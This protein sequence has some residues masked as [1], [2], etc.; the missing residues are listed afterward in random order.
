MSSACTSID[1]GD[2]AVCYA[3]RKVFFAENMGQC[4]TC[5][6]DLCLNLPSC[7]DKCKCDEQTEHSANNA[8]PSTV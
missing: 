8:A 6:A 3:C 4:L 5:G 1:L 2:L 7:S